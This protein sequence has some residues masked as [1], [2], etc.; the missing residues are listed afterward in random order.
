MS[1]LDL[2][3]VGG[4]TGGGGEDL[5]EEVILNESLVNQLDSVLD[6]NTDENLVPSNIKNGISIYGVMGNL[7]TLP[8]SWLSS[9]TKVAQE[10][11]LANDA[12]VEYNFRGLNDPLG[13]TQLPNLTILPSGASNDCAY[14]A[15]GEFFAVAHN[16]NP[17]VTIYK[18]TG[19]KYAKLANPTTLPTGTGNAC[20]FSPNGDYLVVGHNSFPYI[21]IYQKQ[22]SD[23]F[24]KIANP[25]YVPTS[26]VKSVA[27]SSDG[28]YLALATDSSPYLIIYY[29]SY[30]TDTFTRVTNISNL[31]TSKSY[32]VDFDTNNNWLLVGE[33]DAPFV[34]LY[35][36]GEDGAFTQTEI[37]GNLN[38]E[39][40]CYG[41]SFNYNNNYFVT[42]N[43]NSP[44][45]S[46]FK[47]NE[48]TSTY[49][50]I[51]ISNIET[52]KPSAVGNGCKFSKTNNYF[53]ITHNGS[54][55]ISNY[56]IGDSDVVTKMATP[57]DLLTEAAT[58][59]DYLGNNLL[60]ITS[61]SVPY[62]ITYSVTGEDIIEKAETETVSN[63]SAFIG[64]GVANENGSA[65]TN[66]SVNLFTPLNSALKGE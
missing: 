28:Q 48:S 44:F 33:N 1:F 38:N 53:T 63:I 15:D 22:D 16:N 25:D 58:R 9:A 6:G 42:S 64:Y 32:C 39:G 65:N 21:T 4:M 55:F 31:P 26:A 7:L 14:S 10:D 13:T 24:E 52:I 54:P 66:V 27:F 29:I 49:D 40:V 50:K 34:L 45:M 20:A 61:K 36:I 3:F 46:V 5:D 56:S 8:S 18:K 2:K 19:N 60:S 17:Y 35:A 43:N 62:V 59:C 30:N 57:A 12:I 41:V 23:N 51:T 11:I 47:Y 37:N